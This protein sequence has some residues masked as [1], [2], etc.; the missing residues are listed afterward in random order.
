VALGIRVWCVN[1]KI[2]GKNE[3]TRFYEYECGKR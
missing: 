3:S 1:I 2:G